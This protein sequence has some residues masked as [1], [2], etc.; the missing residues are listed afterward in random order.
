MKQLA[1][2]AA[3]ALILSA[4]VGWAQ[5]KIQS[6]G[7]DVPADKVN[8][9][10]NTTFHVVAEEFHLRDNADLRFPVTLVL[11]DSNE[12]V[13]GDEVSKTYVIYMERWNEAKFALAASRIAVQHL[14]SEE[15]KNRMVSEIVRRSDQVAPVS[16]QALRYRN[17]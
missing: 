7:V 6:N 11:G 16:L 13:L 3:F 4:C 8:V 5:V 10:Y 15:R 2:L 12:R 9:L 1:R 17:Q 14:V